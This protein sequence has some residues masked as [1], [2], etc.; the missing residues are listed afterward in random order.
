MKRIHISV[1]VL[2]LSCFQAASE[3]LLLS[4]GGHVLCLSEGGHVLFI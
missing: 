1:V 4:E 3:A 2:V